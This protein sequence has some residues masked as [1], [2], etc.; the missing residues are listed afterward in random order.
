M[1]RFVLSWV[2]RSELGRPRL[3]LLLLCMNALSLLAAPGPGRAEV[4]VL[5]VR[6]RNASELL[7]AVRALLTE[8][9][10]AAA[11]AQSNSLVIVDRPEAVEQVRRFLAGLDKPAPQARITVRFEE[12][13]ISA[14]QGLSASGS[15]SRGKG[16][17]RLGG[18]SSD[19][20][21]LEVRDGKREG[22]SASQFFLRVSSGSAAYILVGKDI[23]YR[24]RWGDLCRRYAGCL[25]TVAFRRIETGMEVTPVLM[26]DRADIEIVP[27]IARQGSGRERDVIRFAEAAMRIT[28]PLGQWVDLGGAEESRNEVM[29]EILSLGR[30][31]E[32]S[33]LAISLMVEGL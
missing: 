30:S 7:P 26:G 14:E 1:K 33:S 8:E 22:Q 11:D 2:F 18:R 31:A 13:G 12:S 19:G 17:V 16:R 5:E 25:E 23:P 6:F 10:R 4:A 24:Q 20:I 29:R 21:E 3:W 28:V 15:V 32:G 9:G 27:R